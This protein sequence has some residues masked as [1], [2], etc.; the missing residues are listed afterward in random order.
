MPFLQ[1]GD[2]ATVP[3]PAGQSIRVGAFRKASASVLIPQGLPGGPLATVNDGASTY[4]PYPAGASV[5]VNAVAGEVEYVVAASPVLTDSPFN[6][7]GVAITGGSLNSTSVGATNQNTGSFTSLRWQTLNVALTDGSGTPGNV[8]QNVSRG[9]AAFAAAASSVVVT[10]SQV[11]ATS[12][13]LVSLGG[14]DATLTS[15]RVTAA[16]GSFTVT[17]NAAAT[18]ATPFDYVV[19][20]N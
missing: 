20:Q 4:G 3:I 14:A 5:T 19:I 15:V 13:I 10:N 2:S 17:G 1:Q 18:A 11:S 12:T 16:A 8:T 6:P 9:R 7:A